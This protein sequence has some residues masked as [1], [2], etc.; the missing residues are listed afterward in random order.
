MSDRTPRQVAVVAGGIA[1]LATAVNLLD[2]ASARG[3][4]LQVTVFE[5][6]ATPGGN[7]QTLRD[8]GW[9]M[10]WGPN[11]FLDSEPATL[12]LAAR[13]GL[14]GELL[15]SSDLTRHRFLLV[16]GRL[17]EIPTSPKA[18]LQSKLMPGRA[19]LRMAGE[20]FV[21]RRRDLGRAADDPATDE[22][23]DAFGRRRLGAEFAEVMLDPM[24][25]GV[26]G[27]DSRKLSLAAAFPRMVEL[28]RDHGGLFKAMAA[29]A[30]QRK[31]AGKAGTDAGPSGVLT[32]FNGGMGQ[33]ID[34]LVGVLQGDPRAELRTGTAVS[35]VGRD[36]GGGWRV[37]GHDFDAGPFDAVVDASPAHA[38]AVHLR[39]VSPVL[40]EQLV[41]IP[42]A[43]MAVLA[44]GF[45]RAAVRHDLQGFGMLIPTREKRELLGVLWTSSIFPRRA[46]EG[47]VLLRCMAGGASN[48]GALDLDDEA[49]LGVT[50]SELRPLLGIKGA[51]EM[52]RI[53]RHQ[54]AIAQYVPGHLAR[55]AAVARE[56]EHHPGLF[57]TGSSYK[58]ISVNYCAK[59]AETVA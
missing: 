4:D 22:T 24:V 45:D 58:G 59:E 29:L 11:G 17:Q 38:A 20:L 10:E 9:Q 14:E 37:A 30:R 7:L 49:L 13:A 2:R 33:L 25:K 3:L 44:L 8:G 27:G 48:P 36:A 12:R 32:S 28:E 15:R 39:E 57:L 34:A 54:R 51:P 53:I 6:A 55:L 46:P 19:K 35:R 50:L 1:G 42:F 47:K 41:K 31:R 18:F 23:V 56:L 26:F 43:P 40:H 21:P 16:D 52:V 5:K